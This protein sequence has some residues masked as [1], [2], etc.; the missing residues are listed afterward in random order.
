MNK[1][2][3]N[4]SNWTEGYDF[5][6]SRIRTT[7]SCTDDREC[8]AP[9]GRALKTGLGAKWDVGYTRCTLETGL[10]N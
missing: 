10:A 6:C 1:M 5:N 4:A 8:I 2:F 9:L 7:C 3:P